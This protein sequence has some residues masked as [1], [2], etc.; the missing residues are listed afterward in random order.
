MSVRIKI[1]ALAVI[2]ILLSVILITIVAVS[3]FDKALAK[4]SEVQLENMIKDK[5]EI[6]STLFNSYGV[7]LKS[8]STSKEI[9][10][11]LVGF[12]DSFYKIEKEVKVDQE[13]LVEELIV[14]Y[15]NYYLNKVDYNLAGTTRRLTD[16]YMPYTLSGKIAQK[17]FILDNPH[18]IGE[19]NELS[20][21]PKYEF[22]S[23]MKEHDIHHPTLNRF[24]KEF[25][26]YD[27]LIVNMKGDIV[28]S[29]YKEKDFATNL[30]RDVYKLS[31]LGR[32]YFRGLKA[33]EGTMVFEDFSYYEP[34]FNESAAFISSPIF[35]DG[36]VQGTLILQLP[37]NNMNTLLSNT[38]AGET[39]EVYLVG[40]DF[41][42]KTEL[43]FKD[44]LGSD[45]DKETGTAIG[46]YEMENEY[47]K[48]ALVG[49][50]GT[51]YYKNYIGRESLMAYAPINIYGTSWAIIGEISI[52]EVTK[53]KSTVVK[54]I[55]LIGIFIS[56]LAIAIIFIF[57]DKF[58]GK[59]LTYIID[60][61]R[62]ISSGEGDLTQRVI[63]T[64]EKD[65][66]GNLGKNVNKFISTIQ[67]LIND[68]KD[69]GETSR[70]VSRSITKVSN[71]ISERI[72]SE[73][74]TLSLISKTGK[75]I[76]INLADTTANIKETKNIIIDSNHI[77]GEA[78]EE[79]G[80]LARKVGVASDN[81]KMLSEKLSILSEN[82]EKIK[83]VL[84]V[85]DDIADQTNLL[86]LN[87]AI[88]A[89]RAGEF[90]KGFAVVAYEVTKL[91]DKTQESLGDVNKIVTIVL[92]E[93]KDAVQL[94]RKSATSISELSVVSSDA[95]RK[96]TD[97]SE[98]MEESVVIIEKTV[99][100]AVD[101]AIKT[102]DI[103]EKIQQISKLSNENIG[104]VNEL[105]ETAE[106]LHHGG[107]K[108]Y[109]KLSFFKS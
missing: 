71:I 23:Y 103:I 37:L 90:G 79:I 35:V 16:Q 4:S 29:T 45:F 66:F 5:S 69:L 91:A 65:E 93:M 73:N 58:M 42:M 55:L 27:I 100:A 94:V 57:V 48:D 107:E 2:S 56:L 12:S 85:I 43:R 70:G 24:L 82:A 63:I 20:F 59:P 53:E 60:T 108:L 31:P 22:I 75:T 28:Y 46:I 97:T 61:T 96:I 74:G 47:V 32:A 95:S 11:S 51:A 54:D 67:S 1:T 18:K 34:S 68:V 19:K 76:S 77:L 44:Q 50:Q 81:Q 64:N 80:Q 105:S 49:K 30:R 39:N 33:E 87:A 84:F 15:D 6:L 92:D 62:D 86:A 14:H 89:A 102:S 7:L 99:Q 52:K 72:K 104:N 88:E 106:V 13:I 83:D 17:I 109:K 78:K 26:L 41:K 8:L 38:I 40:K 3:S 10:D 9:K 101:S 21:D 25:G 36:K 98:N